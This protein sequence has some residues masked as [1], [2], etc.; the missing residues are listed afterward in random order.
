MDWGNAFIRVSAVFFCSCCKQTSCS[1]ERKPVVWRVW[2]AWCV[3]AAPCDDIIAQRSD[4]ASLVLADVIL[5]EK[6]Y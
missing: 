2:T 1:A 5:H 6:R 4:A 3:R